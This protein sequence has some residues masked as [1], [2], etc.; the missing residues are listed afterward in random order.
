[1]ASLRPFSRQEAAEYSGRLFDVGHTFPIGCAQKRTTECAVR[2]TRVSFAGGVIE[3]DAEPESDGRHD[4]SEMG[5][6][7]DRSL[8]LGTQYL[9]QNQKPDGTFRYKVD[10]ETGREEPEQNAVRQ[11]G[12]LWGLALMHG[13]SPQTETRNAVIRGL[14]FYRRHSAVTAEGGRFVRFPGAIE[15]DSGIVALVAL[16]LIDFLEAEPPGSHKAW[17]ADLQQYLQFLN[18]LQ[19]ADHRFSSHYLVSTGQGWGVPSPYFDGEILLAS[20]RAFARHALDQNAAALAE[21]ERLVKAADA[22]YAAYARKAIAE[23][24]DLSETKG[25]YQWACMAFGQIDGLAGPDSPVHIDRTLALSNWMV[26]VHRTLERKG[27]T[28]YAVEGLVTAYRLAGKRDDREAA[29]Q[30]RVVIEQTLAK[31]LTWQV[32]GPD[33]NQFLS[34]HVQ[35]DRR[36]MGGVLSSASNPILRIDTTQHQMHALMMARQFVWPDVT[37]PSKRVPQAQG[38]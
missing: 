25:F 5:G 15:G 31:L 4:P 27:N 19:R 11:A 33:P 24:T 3:S 37:G 28:A 29:E 34:R 16:A 2:T 7:I 35:I 9:V 13:R 12:A 14:E 22:M 8:Q 21:R 6:R 18:S 32:G 30:L 26:D 23:R 17:E 20:A 10:L 36:L 1:M 38:R